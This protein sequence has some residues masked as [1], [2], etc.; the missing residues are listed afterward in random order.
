MSCYD[1]RF[2]DSDSS[3]YWVA[4]LVGKSYRRCHRLGSI[5]RE[6]I[7]TL[8]THSLAHTGTIA[9]YPVDTHYLIAR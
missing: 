2:V 7:D 6:C 8:I 1:E 9:R 5:V 3:L 4:T